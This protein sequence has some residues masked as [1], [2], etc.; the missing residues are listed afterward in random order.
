M[1]AKKTYS[2]RNILRIIL[3]ILFIFVF[4]IIVFFFG[5]ANKFSAFSS[6]RSDV[7][8]AQNIFH[9][10]YEAQL[11][12][13]N[14]F[15]DD[16]I[17]F[18]TKKNRY[19]R[20]HKIM[21]QYVYH[22][23]DS[24]RNVNL[25]QKFGVLNY[26]EDFLYY[27][28]KEAETFDKLVHKLYL[29]GSQKTGSIGKVY[30]S[31]K[32]VMRYSA[33]L[34]GQ[35]KDPILAQVYKL[36]QDFFNYLRKPD[37]KYY[38]QFLNDYIQIQKILNQVAKTDTATLSDSLSLIQNTVE[39]PLE[40]IAA[41][42]KYKTNFTS[43]YNSDKELGYTSD[44]GVMQK[45]EDLMAQT[46]KNLRLFGE[47]L[48]GKFVI[49]FKKSTA[50]FVVLLFLSYF[51]FLFFIFY[52][53]RSFSKI[54]SHFYENI[55]PLQYGIL[56][57]TISIKK[58]FIQEVA[59][60]VSIIN[61]VI[62]SLN[63]MSLFAEELT[64]GNFQTE[65]KP[66]S[67]KDKLGNSL[68]KLRDSLLKAKEEE[69]KR[70]EQDRINRWVNEGISKFA[71]LL[72]QVAKD[73]HELS[74]VV[75]KNLVDYLGANQG[76]IFLINDEDKENVYLELY[77]AYAYNKE[78]KKQKVIAL[79]EGL[80]GTVAI[81]KATMYLTEIPEDYVSITSGLGGATPRSLLIVPLIQEEEVLGVIEIA[82]FN[83]FEKYQIDFVE[84]IAEN[85]AATISITKI[86][87]RTTRL[88]EQ[89][90]KQTEEMAAKEE[91]MRQNLEELQATQE[92][93][94]RREAELTSILSA[95]KSIAYVFELDLEG[96]ILTVDDRVLSFY[97][98]P[99]SFFLGQHF[100]IID[101][102]PTSPLSNEEFWRKIVEHKQNIVYNRT[103]EIDDKTVW[104]E[105]HF[106][107]VIDA[108]GNVEK[109]LVISLEITK[110]IM[111]EEQ[112]KKQQ[113]YTEQQAKELAKKIEEM[114]R[115]QQVLEEEKRKTDSLVVKLKNSEEVLKKALLK[116][117]QDR[118]KLNELYRHLHNKNI[119]LQNNTETVLAVYEIFQYLNREI[120]KDKEFEQLKREKVEE[121]LLKLDKIL[122]QKEALVYKL[123]LQI[124]E[125]KNQ[126]KKL[127]K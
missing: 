88:L 48:A 111:Q 82:S 12:F 99:K 58:Q 79:G 68:L 7:E 11:N 92:E 91:E 43:L 62:D 2:L 95:V 61:K 70:F 114:Q 18:R 9:I 83:Y 22:L 90:K 8:L 103:F 78:R 81:E 94:A 47:T 71:D 108:K 59:D 76:A 36:N 50:F 54:F 112:L 93:A 16:E 41:L 67:D 77:A 87:E 64:K 101:N 46:K 84:K 34:K 37:T 125:L 51:I 97:K 21:Y 28:K 30:D 124:E 117:K 85:I 49:I 40:F 19:L 1:N 13:L 120:Q 52:S 15:S 42:N 126:I 110:R 98:L 119:E 122:E 23:L 89:S 31:Y 44:E 109:I 107:P 20:R 106:T 6:Y 118:E 66:L 115:M 24:L 73:L 57:G 100:S 86:N 65:F 14:K 60:T 123:R 33:K 121:K 29:R 3:L 127:N 75:I 80:V 113:E 74:T 69:A 10:D 55:Q 102:N 26:L 105:D 35:K 63:H 17:F 27:Y 4:F 104:F 39:L 32:D 72:R 56:P 38:E 96:N 5:F 116:S 45:W 25:T 53:V